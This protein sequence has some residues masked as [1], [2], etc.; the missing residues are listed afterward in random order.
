MEPTKDTEAVHW[1]VFSLQASF[2]SFI[3]RNWTALWDNS[4][5]EGFISFFLGYI[6]LFVYIG[7]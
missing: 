3:L 2:I 1:Q 6:Y 4:L 7:S 5:K